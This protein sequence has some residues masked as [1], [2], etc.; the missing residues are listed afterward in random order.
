MKIIRIMGGIGN[1][2]FQYAFG[3][4]L[5]DEVLFDVTWFE[6][7]IKKA[8]DIKRV[9]GLGFFN[10]DVP[11]ASEEQ[12]AAC[13]DG[14]SLKNHRFIEDFKRIF[15]QKYKR[16]FN[17]IT[18]LS[19]TPF[20]PSLLKIKGDVYYMGCFQSEKYFANIRNEIL[21]DFSL[22]E[23]MSD[24]NQEMLDKIKSTN[25]VSLHIRRGDYVHLQET[26]GLCGLDYY[27]KAI[28]FI[29]SHSENPHFFLFSDDIAWVVENLK[30][31]HPFTIVDI[32]DGDTGHFDLEL[33]KNCKHNIIANSSFSW[34]GAWLNENPDKIVVAPKQWF[35]K[36]K[37]NSEDIVP[38][39]WIRF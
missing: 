19:E 35:I 15:G 4:A 9:Y 23:K 1:Q 20:D 29:A 34:W 10:C 38:E 18:E 32:N 13:L 2:M 31:E 16:R 25:A 33:M 27:K 26:H 36:K 5:D 30:I 39:N 6:R 8:L 22:K 17:K 37:M 21:K 7:K 12:I 11:V 14:G 24:E 3:R 28:D